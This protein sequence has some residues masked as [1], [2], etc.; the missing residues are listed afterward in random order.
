MRNN[1]KAKRWAYVAGLVDGDGSI[2]LTEYESPKQVHFFFSLKVVST[3]RGQINWL[4]QQ[5]GGQ[6]H[7]YTD[8]REINR[9]CYTWKVIGQH[10]KEILLNIRPYMV[11][12]Q[13]AADK[14]IE[15]LSLPFGHENPALR[16]KFA[17]ELCAINDKFV[18][19][20]YKEAKP[21]LEKSSTLSREEL[22]YA[23]GIL[24]AE[25]TFSL[26]TPT[27]LSPQIQLSSTDQRMLDWLYDRFGGI[28]FVSKKKN[29]EHRDA[30]LWRL[31]GGRCQKP[32]YLQSVKKTKELFLLAILPYMV[33][34]RQQ[35]IL[36]LACLR[37]DKSSRYCFDEL[38][39]LNSVGTSTTNMS[40][41]PENGLKIEPD[42]HSDMQ[43][44][45]VVMLAS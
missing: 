26:P 3:Q 39:K 15:Y 33:Q 2:S 1:I 44:E 7:K 40:N 29:P 5:F 43:C 30:G 12:K 25:G 17:T 13:E 34:K 35:A 14:A 27:A 42:L 16:S 20:E 38:K 19:A 11:L 23:A 9:P 21:L 41:S 6:L 18:Q 24:D 4:I 37:S 28:T 36:S 8:K 32:E 10:A 22:A 31:S 45:P